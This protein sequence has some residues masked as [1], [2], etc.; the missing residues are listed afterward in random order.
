M[1]INDLT[2]NFDGNNNLIIYFETSFHFQIPINGIR[3]SVR[4]R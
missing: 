4:I 2:A 3:M 1:G